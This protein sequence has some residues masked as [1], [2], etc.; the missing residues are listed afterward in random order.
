MKKLRYLFGLIIAG[1]MAISTPAS[2]IIVGSASFI[3]GDCSDTSNT[4]T[5]V[6]KAPSLTINPPQ[7]VVFDVA[8]GEIVN[9]HIVAKS[10][11]T[12]NKDL[13]KLNFHIKYSAGKPEFDTTW[14]PQ[15]TELKEFTKDYEYTVPSS[16]AYGTVITISVSA[17]DVDQKVGKKTFVL[18]LVDLSGLNNYETVTLGA[19]SNADLGS[20]YATSTNLVYKVNEAKT[21]GQTTID[22]VYFYGSTYTASIASPANSTVF[23]TGAGQISVLKVHEWTTRNAT[24]FKIIPP[25]TLIDWDGLNTTNISQK[26]AVAGSEVDLAPYLFDGT[27]GSQISHVLFKT[28]KNKVGMFK[29]KNING[30]DATGS[31]VLNVKVQK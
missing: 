16:L 7:K 29:V 15:A 3:Y 20:F 19:Q 10:H 1:I 14:Y 8:R 2:F 21:S 31:I 5:I 17:T 13:S 18:T 12:T 30:Y 26:W 4:D 25:L 28:S 6:V 27:G 24:K 23:G 22:F 11:A 9:F